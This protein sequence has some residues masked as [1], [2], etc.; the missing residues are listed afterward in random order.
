MGPAKKSHTIPIFWYILSDYAAALLSSNIFHFSRRMLLSEPIFVGHRLLLTSRFWLGTTTIPLGWLILYTLVGSYKSLY[1]KSRLSE[2]ANTFIYC[3]IGCTIVFFSIVI[4]DPV[5]DYHYFYQT[6]IIFLSAHFLLT[7]TGRILILNKV[8]RQ[9]AKGKVVFNTLLVGSDAIATHIYTSSREGLRSSG[10]QYTGY[11]TNPH[12]LS[13]GIAAH[14]PQL[15]DSDGIEKT[16]DQHDIR[17]V[18]VA[19]ERS[20]RKEV[21]TILEKLSNKDVRIK[22]IPSTLDI[23]SGSVRTSNVM[24]AVLSD[25]HTGLM[26]EWQQNIKRVTDILVAGAGLILLSPLMLYAALRTRLSSAGPI[27]YEQ[28]R[29]GYKGIKFQIYKFRSMYPDAEKDGPAL[30]SYDD[31]RVTP[32]GKKM[33]KW[34]I[35]ELPQLWNI[36]KGEMSLVG[37]RPEREYYVNQ[38]HLRTPYFRYLLKVKPGLTSWGMVQFGYAENVEEM[39]ERMK[40]DLMYIENISPV[41][42]W[43]I[44]LH[45]LR[46]IFTAQGR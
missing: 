33:R 16:I 37:P 30:S 28:E 43:K 15:G 21:E 5:K 24:G 23:L 26:P 17:L 44:M 13:N 39:V 18:V 14:L 12:E 22:I 1:Q 20:A 35:D 36:L 34:R 45:T 2:V 4:N 25:I 41:L 46:I 8:H 3:L 9:V 42:D 29:I 31:Q 11:V 27:F 40:Y 38:L 6:Y 32:W 7:L 19:L 10:Y